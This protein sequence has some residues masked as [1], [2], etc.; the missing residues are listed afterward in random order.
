MSEQNTT[1]GGAGEP[2][3]PKSKSQLMAMLWLDKAYNDAIIGE[4]Q[5]GEDHGPH[6]LF[7]GDSG[8]MCRVWKRSFYPEKTRSRRMCQ[9][10]GGVKPFLHYA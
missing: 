4:S 10:V 3:R 5:R 9:I 6:P 2:K 8:R 1:G 7:P